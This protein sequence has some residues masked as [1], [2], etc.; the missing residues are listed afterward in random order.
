VPQVETKEDRKTAKVCEEDE[1]HELVLLLIEVVVP[2]GPERAEVIGKT[3][4]G[5]GEEEQVEALIF[6]PN[7]VVDPGRVVVHMEHTPI[8]Y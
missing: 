8:A 4:E 2:D 7:A 1:I 3:E 6:K 5:I